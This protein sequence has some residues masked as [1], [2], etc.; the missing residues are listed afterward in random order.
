M[1]MLLEIPSTD[2]TQLTF[3]E[4]SIGRI[5]QEAKR[6]TPF[7]VKRHVNSHIKE[8]HRTR[9]EHDKKNVFHNFSGVRRTKH[10]KG[11]N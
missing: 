5:A 3:C 8:M 6:A 10:G 2:S 1:S 7:P 4:I 11:S 9:V